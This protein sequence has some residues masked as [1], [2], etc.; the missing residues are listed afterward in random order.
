MSTPDNLDLSES[1]I[2]SNISKGLTFREQSRQWE[3]GEEIREE[4]KTKNL[5]KVGGC[6][7]V[8]VDKRIHY[9]YSGDEMHPLIDLIR[10][11]LKKMEY[12]MREELG[13]IYDVRFV[14]HDV[15]AESKEDSLRVHCEKLAIGLALVSGHLELEGG[16]IR[17][18]KNL[19]ICGDCH[20]FMKGLSKV[21]K[22]TILVRDA[23]RFHKF[24]DGQCSCKDFW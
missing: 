19:R 17:I 21:L 16:V 5:K 2:V 18:F 6:S 20:G 15:E 11:V 8:E 14:L 3:K 24:Q 4:A 7:W 23:N 13:Y 9:F 22:K 12:R 1:C 10:D